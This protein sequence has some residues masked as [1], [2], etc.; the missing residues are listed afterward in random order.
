M[1]EKF[2][3]ACMIN[4]LLRIIKGSYI[5]YPSPVDFTQAVRTCDSINA[6]VLFIDDSAED[7]FIRT[8]Y[9]NNNSVKDGIWLA[10]FDFIGDE[11]NVNYY[12]NQS[13]NYTNWKSGQPNNKK[14]FCT[15]YNKHSNNDQW[16]DETSSAQHSVLC[17]IEEYATNSTTTTTESSRKTDTLMN[18][19][20]CLEL[21]P[22]SF[23]QLHRHRNNK[24]MTNGIEYQILNVSCSLIC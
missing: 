15:F 10:I 24:N 13:L 5:L 4:L 21:N 7:V 9:L 20:S 11:T 3:I 16:G 22:W 19:L 12:A 8:N 18:T 6:T 14:N 1:K 17:E 23:C 2:I